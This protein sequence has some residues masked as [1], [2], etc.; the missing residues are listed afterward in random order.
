MP[1]AS[2]DEKLTMSSRDRTFSYAVGTMFA[3]I[4]DDDRASSTQRARGT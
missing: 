4:T 2:I 3:Q 1:S